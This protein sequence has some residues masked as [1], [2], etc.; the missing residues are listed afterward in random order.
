MTLLRLALAALF[1]CAL[2]LVALA[3]QANTTV[4][5]GASAASSA[6]AALG[7][8][9]QGGTITAPKQAPAA[10]AP[11]LATSGETCMGST[12]AGASGAGFGLSFGTTWDSAE[13]QRRMNS[14]QLRL[15]GHND[16]A[17]ALLCA[18]PGVADALAAVG[19]RCPGAPAPVALAPSAPASDYCARNPSDFYCKPK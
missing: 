12:S 11:S 2:P 18:N 8:G 15:L 13:C 10:S 5:N 17:L 14:Q 6:S 4:N 1:A 16:A 7:Y 3:Q 19:K 9:G